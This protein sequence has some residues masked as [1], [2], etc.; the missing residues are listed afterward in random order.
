MWSMLTE[1]GFDCGRGDG[2]NRETLRGTRMAHKGYGATSRK[3]NLRR[4]RG[5]KIEPV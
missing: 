2:E 5:K 1:S 4:C 3:K